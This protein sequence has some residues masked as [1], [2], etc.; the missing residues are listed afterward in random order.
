VEGETI[1]RIQKNTRTINRI[2]IK[3]VKKRLSLNKILFILLRFS[4][5]PFIFRQFVQNKKVTIL[6]FHDINPGVAERTFTYLLKKYHIIDLNTF[7]KASEN[8]N[9]KSLPQNA[10]I[11][12]F[13]D[14]FLRNFK[15]L[16]VIQKY[17][18]PVTIFICAGLINT[19]RELWFIFNRKKLPGVSFKDTPN[20]ERLKILMQAGFIQTDESSQPQVLSK[21]HINNMKAHVNFQSHTMYHPF[22]PM[23]DDEEVTTELNR[24]REI[25]ENEYHLTIN[26]I[27]YPFGHYSEKIIELAR[28]A[29]YKCGITVDYGFN[30]I[31]SDLFRLKRLLVN[32]TDDIN[33]LIIKSSGVWGFFKTFVKKMKQRLEK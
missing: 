27:A 1:P 13:D 31:H 2:P 10:L 25:L 26:T 7:I 11:I 4:G 23:C 8:K 12:T 20:S 30:S 6:C 16:S 33:E 24:S 9:S 17:Q 29:G 21:D 19:N 18:I 3:Q 14:G 32:D 22:L 28:G 15:L 5:L